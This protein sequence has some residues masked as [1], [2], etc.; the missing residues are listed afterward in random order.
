MRWDA[1]LYKDRHSFVPQLGIGV[2][3]LLA[4]KVGER[5]LD[6]GCGPN[7]GRTVSGL[8]TTAA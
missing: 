3:D 8:Q 4:P 5:I 2:V 7:C 1:Q 6:V